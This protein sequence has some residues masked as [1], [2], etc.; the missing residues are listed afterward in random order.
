MTGDNGWEW[1]GQVVPSHVAD[2]KHGDIVCA[3]AVERRGDQ[4]MAGLCRITVGSR[5]DV[6]NLFVVQHFRQSVRTEQQEVVPFQG[7]G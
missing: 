3:A 4:A 1:C 5:T 6:S 7:A 2:N